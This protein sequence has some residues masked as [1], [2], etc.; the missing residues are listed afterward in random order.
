MRVRREELTERVVPDE[1]PPHLPPPAEHTLLPGGADHYRRTLSIQ[2]SPVGVEPQQDPAEVAD[3]L[4]HREPTDDVE[5][6]EL[7]E[8]VRL[9]LRA[10][11][12]RLSF[13]PRRVFRRPPVAEHS[14]A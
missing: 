4:S 7:R 12:R 11:L 1:C 14:G 2:R 10:P 9:V 8:V 5:A 13:E 6:R 3:V